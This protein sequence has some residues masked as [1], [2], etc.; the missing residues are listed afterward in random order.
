VVVGTIDPS[1]LADNCT[2]VQRALAN[3]QETKSK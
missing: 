2:A 3:E 1:H